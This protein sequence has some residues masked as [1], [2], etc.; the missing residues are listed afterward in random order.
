MILDFISLE[1]NDSF[2]GEAPKIYLYPGTD[3]HSTPELN[4]MISD[5]Q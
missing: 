5:P 1:E 4:L 3:A 2:S